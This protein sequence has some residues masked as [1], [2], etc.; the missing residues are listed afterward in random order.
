[1]V[2]IENTESDAGYT[3]EELPAN[4]LVAVAPGIGA[5]LYKADFSDLGAAIDLLPKLFP[6]L[7][8]SKIIQLWKAGA[9]KINGVNTPF[10]KDRCI[11]MG[12]IRRRADDQFEFCK[13]PF[14]I[15]FQLGK[16]NRA[17]IVFEKPVFEFV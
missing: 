5:P 6:D 1:M 14:I 3:P 12:D 17:A 7:A 9:L 13:L 4:N 16:G 11:W 15:L 2:T 10:N 8:K